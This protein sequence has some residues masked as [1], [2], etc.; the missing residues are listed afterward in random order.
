MRQS[1]RHHSY[2]FFLWSIKL[3]FILLEEKLEVQEQES[4]ER[5]F[6]QTEMQIVIYK[7]TAVGWVKTI[8]SSATLAAVALCVTVHQWS[9]SLPTPGCLRPGEYTSE[10]TLLQDFF[11]PSIVSQLAGILWSSWLSP[12]GNKLYNLILNEK[13]N[14]FPLIVLEKCIPNQKSSH[15][16]SVYF[17]LLWSK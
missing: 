10:Y 16:I 9:C 17:C 11:F 5:N 13:E 3:I 1:D 12:S 2:S 4:D 8:C 15:Q 6:W 7:I 14:C